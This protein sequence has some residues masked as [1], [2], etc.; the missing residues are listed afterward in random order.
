MDITVWLIIVYLWASVP[1]GYIIAKIFTGKDIRQYGSGNIGS[2]NVKRIGGKRIALATQL[3]DMAKGLLP[4]F[5][6][7]YALPLSSH[8]NI[9]DSFISYPRLCT[10]STAICSIM[11][12]NFSIFLRFKGGKGVNTTL[13]ASLLI[14]PLVVLLAVPVYYITKYLSHYV[15]LGSICL[16][17]S[18]PLFEYLIYGSNENFYYFIICSVFIILSHQKNIQRLIRKQEPKS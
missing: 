12:H 17:L 7:M 16:G 4:V 14:S 18:L 9:N 5:L 1:Y 10:Y 13:G 6:I 3:L 11:G 2:T 8:D 15:S